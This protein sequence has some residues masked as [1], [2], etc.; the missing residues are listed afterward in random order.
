[1]IMIHHANA[2]NS[3]EFYDLLVTRPAQSVPLVVNDNIKEP[4]EEEEDQEGQE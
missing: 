3:I 4:E 2:K 1:M